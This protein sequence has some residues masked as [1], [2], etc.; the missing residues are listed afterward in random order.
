MVEFSKVEINLKP[1][2]SGTIVKI[3][4]EKLT[5]ITNISV[6]HGVGE[7]PTVRITMFGDITVTGEAKITKNII[8]KEESI[9]ERNL[10]ND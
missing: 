3:N 5:G 7:L 6:N 2:T 4:G 9:S 8:T 10:F 1:D